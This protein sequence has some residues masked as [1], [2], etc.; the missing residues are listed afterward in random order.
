MGYM[1]GCAVFT[2]AYYQLQN[3]DLTLRYNNIDTYVQKLI[4]I[5]THVRIL[6]GAGAETK[7]WQWRALV[8]SL[9]PS[10]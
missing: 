5:Q 6:T 9:G 8:S 2:R 3:L 4:R 7:Y 10:I 1:N